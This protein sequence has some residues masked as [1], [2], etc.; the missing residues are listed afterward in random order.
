MAKKIFILALF[1]AGIF[2][3]AASIRAAGE[4]CCAKCGCQCDL[5]CVCRPVQTTK[6]VEIT[7][8]DCVCED[9]CLPPRTRCKDSC[10]AGD[11]NAPCDAC[12][13]VKIR[14]CNKLVRKTYLKPIPTV[15]WVV[16][17]LCPNC[18]CADK[19]YP[20]AQSEESPTK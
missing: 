20:A 16:E 7:C 19:T 2:L 11:E 14:S 17:Y 6:Y 18:R 10:P 3:T 5:Q 12:K 4:K 8:W 13:G 9:V 15:V 1:L